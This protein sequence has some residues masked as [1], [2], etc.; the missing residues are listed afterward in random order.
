MA[1]PYA[2]RIALFA[3]VST[4][5][6]ARDDKDSLPSQLRDGQ[7]WAEAVS[8]QVVATYRMPG[9]S[10]K[11]IFYQDIEKAVPAYRELREDC[12]AGAFDVLWCRAR[13]R[14]DRSPRRSSGR[15]PPR[16]TAGR[17]RSLGGGWACA[18]C[19]A[20]RIRSAAVSPVS[21]TTVAEAP[22]RQSPLI[23]AWSS[24]LGPPSCEA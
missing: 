17:P 15:V 7:A 13:D 18:I 19:P 21:P 12:E 10:R 9:H 6:Q 22:T 8:G 11:Y 4:P 23:T 3:S 16:L 2:L 5:Q 20:K 1:P 24:R 14:Q